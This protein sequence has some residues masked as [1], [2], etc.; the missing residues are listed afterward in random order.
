MTDLPTRC[1]RKLGWMAQRAGV[2][3]R[4]ASFPFLAPQHLA[5]IGRE[6]HLEEVRHRALVRS[7]AF[8]VGEGTY[9]SW[10]VSVALETWGEL[11]VTI[12]ERCAIGT[13]VTFITCSVP[14]KS[15][16]MEIEGF[17]ERF[18]IRNAPITIGDD[19]WIGVGAVIL[20]GVRVGNF[21]LVGAGSVVTSDVP[22]YA[23][24]AGVPARQVGDVRRNPE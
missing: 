2:A 13:Y 1:L 11:A 15:R 4:F 18:V 10:G 12:G 23:V 14:N 16:Q 24:V 8:A 3:L 7:K 20:P 5:R 6:H 9:F 19:T 21:C 17:E 22:D